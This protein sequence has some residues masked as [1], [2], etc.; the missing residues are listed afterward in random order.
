MRTPDPIA[1]E[2]KVAFLRKPSSYPGW[3]RSVQV[4]ETHFA[5]VFLTPKHAYKL[6]KP[7]RHPAMDYRSVVARR[8]GCLNEVRLNRRLASKVYLAAVPLRVRNGLLSLGGE[9]RIEDWL[10]KMRRLGSSSMLDR[11]LSHRALRNAELDCIVAHLVTFFARAQRLPMSGDAYVRRLQREVAINRN[12]LGRAGSRIRQALVRAV[13]CNQSLFLSKAGQLL[14]Q[15]GARVVEGHGD[16]R[17]EHVCLGPPPSVIDCLEFS[18]DLRLFDPAEELAVLALEIE[19]LGHPALAAE[20]MR[21]FRVASGDPVPDAIISFYLSHRA[22]TRAK[23]AVWHL[24]DPQF[25]DA[26]PWVARTHSYLRDA[27]RHTRRALRLLR[28]LS[29]PAADADSA[30]AKVVILR[31]RPRNVL[32]AM[33]V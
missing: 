19:R 27:L 23:L 32:G 9:G 22:A 4:I 14:G 21:R 7:V 12:E 1:L 18:R 24:G 11:T 15:R 31:G 10:V 13:T 3:V 33:S 8:R 20:L 5:W 25:P 6:K 28:P 26:R 16:L 29:H 17:A 30:A 2:D